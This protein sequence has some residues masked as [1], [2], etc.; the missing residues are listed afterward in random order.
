MSSP[1]ILTP[2]ST[3]PVSPP[4]LTPS[5]SQQSGSSAYPSSLSSHYSVHHRDFETDDTVSVASSSSTIQKEF[6]VPDLWRP[7]IMQCINAPTPGEQKKLLTS[8]VRGEL[9]RDLVTHMHAFKAKPDRAFC[10]TV[11]EVVSEE[12][13]IHEGCWKECFRL[14]KLNFVIAIHNFE[15]KYKLCVFEA[16]VPFQ[17]LYYVHS[18]HAD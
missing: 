16:F 1:T 3:T 8:S 17:R 4:L 7:S 13:S 18:K 15:C 12:V 2:S 9:S 10:T 11:A 14:C 6:T 5:C